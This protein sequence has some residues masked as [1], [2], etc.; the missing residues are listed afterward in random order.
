M[1]YYINIQDST[2]IIPAENL[3]EAYNRMCQLNFT[4]PN[5]HK[6]GG[7]YSSEGGKDTAPEYG[8]HDACWFSWMDWDYHEKCSDVEEILDHLGFQIEYDEDGNLC[9]CGYDSKT[10]QEDLF[11]KSIC[12][13]AKGYIIWR[14]EEGEV[15]GE[16]YGGKEVIRKYQKD[17]SHLVT[18]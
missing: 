15:W 3:T 9:I 12:D 1:G 8:P 17:Y 7:R 11:L 18:L 10:G 14:G 4:V 16:T 5:K 2:F 6:S 13:L